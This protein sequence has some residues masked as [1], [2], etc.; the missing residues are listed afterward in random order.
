MDSPWY[1]NDSLIADIAQSYEMI[2]K[3][4]KDELILKLNDSNHKKFFSYIRKQIVFLTQNQFNKEG[5][6]VLEYLLTIENKYYG[7]FHINIGK[8][9]E[10]KGKL[11]SSI[12]ENKKA[13]IAFEQ[14]L[15]VYQELNEKVYIENVTQKIKEIQALLQS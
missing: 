12:G 13:I 7:K 11:L 3:I 14:S 5:L 10:L 8:S 4:L 6:N 2:N 1:E 9:M 15:K